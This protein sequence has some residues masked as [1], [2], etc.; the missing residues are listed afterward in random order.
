MSSVKKDPLA[1]ADAAAT[2]AATA[3]PSAGTDAASSPS[4]SPAAPTSKGY[5]RFLG[6]VPL[7]PWIVFL[8]VLPVACYVVYLSMVNAYQSRTYALRDFGMVI[9]EFDPWFNFRATQYLSKHGWHAFFHW[10]DYMSW[11]P[12]GRPVG[13]TIYPGLQITAVAIH[14]ALRWLGKPYAMSLNNVCCTIPCWFGA[15]ATMFLALLTY[16]CSGS[17]SAAAIASAIMAIVPAHMM[18]SVGGG[19]DNECIAMSAMIITFY[20]WVRSLRT[21][22]SWGWGVLTGLAYGY[23]VA[24]WGGFIFVL[25]MVVLHAAVLALLDMLRNRYSTRL[26]YAYSLFYVIGTAIATTVPP[27][28]MMPFKSLEQLSATLLFVVLAALHL[29]ERERVAANANV[30][31]L[32]ALK[33]RVKYVG[34]ALLVLG[35]FA[36]LIAPAGFFGPLSSR[37]RALFVKHMKTGNPLVDSVAEHRP[38]SADAYWTY[39]H[40]ANSLW[41][42]GLVAIWLLQKQRLRAAS[43]LFCYGVA[44]Y[45]FSVR[46]ARLILLAA[47]VASA[48]SGVVLGGALDWVAAQ[49]WFSNEGEEPAEPRSGME[50]VEQ[51]AETTTGQSLGIVKRGVAVLLVAAAVAVA[52]GKWKEFAAHSDQLANSFSQPRVIL[53]QWVGGRPVLIDDY[54]E[55]YFWLRDHTPEDSRVLSWWDYGYQITGI[56]NRTTLADGNTWNHEHIATIGVMLS[57]PVKQAHKLIRHVADYVLV[58]AGQGN[59]DL[60]KSPHMARIGNSVYRGHCPNDPLCSQFTFHRPN[61]EDPTPMMRNSLL[62]NAVSHNV[63]PGVRMDPKYFTEAF[64]SK[65]GLVRI[66]KVVNVSQE[67]KAWIADPANR[68]CDAPGSWYCNGQYPQV[69]VWKEL[70][71]KRRDFGQLEDHSKPDKIDHEYHRQY[72]EAQRRAGRGG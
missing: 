36:T 39:L 47:P 56:G 40:Y 48:L 23:M 45:F 14:R 60:G 33:V 34:G 46:M 52:P 63:K 20:F 2:T 13:T 31:S 54:R 65:H 51:V 69:K 27:V 42:V 62:Y 12:L 58:W 26:F 38:A 25:N 15:L 1:A 35:A 66:F 7:P 32:T 8:A 61:Y 29:S 67:T 19:F 44:A 16:E 57:S 41:H 10:F 55:A 49:L 64:T 68:K 5:P 72:M 24:A 59:D 4:A 21:S 18:R 71:A 22:G 70:I 30:L 11:Y 37:V 6:V 43:F 3:P 28:G 53:R 17:L 9:H 50:L